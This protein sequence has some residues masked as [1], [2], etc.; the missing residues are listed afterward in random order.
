MTEYTW[1]KKDYKEIKK[2][3][4][5]CK[6]DRGHFETYTKTYT[7]EGIEYR[8]VVNTSGDYIEVVDSSLNNFRYNQ[9]ETISSKYDYSSPYYMGDILDCLTYIL[10]VKKAKLLLE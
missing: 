8:I 3:I 2:F 4:E 6:K 10:K 5:A 9:G 1:N 7:F